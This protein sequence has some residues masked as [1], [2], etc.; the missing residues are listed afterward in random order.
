MTNSTILMRP[1][2]L[3][4]HLTPVNNQMKVQKMLFL[5][6]QN[7]QPFGQSYCCY[8]AIVLVLTRKQKLPL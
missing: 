3:F 1:V 5:K 2:K 4:N 8:S 7:L 6:N